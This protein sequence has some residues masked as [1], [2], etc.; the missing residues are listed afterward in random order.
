MNEIEVVNLAQLMERTSGDSG[1][2]IGLIDGPVAIAHPALRGSNIRETDSFK[3]KSNPN[4]PAC[5]HGTFVAGILSA[6][7][8]SGAPAIC[9]GCT[10]L[11][12]PILQDPAPGD[13]QIPGASAA[14]LAAAIVD[15]VNAG[16]RVLN[17]S[18]EVAQESADGRS[19]L[20]D[21]L[22]YAA[23]AGVIVAAAAG[24]QSTLAGSI[25]T[26]H[27]CVIPVAACDMNGMPTGES[28]L[29][30]TIGRRGLR[31]PGNGITSIGNG[32]RPLARGGTSVATPF[33][34]GTVALL[35][36]LFPTAPADRIRQAVT[37]GAKPR[38]AAVT[39][40]LLNAQAAYQV[41][42]T[43]YSMR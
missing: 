31:A 32:G 9:P 5:Q 21:A 4:S 25:I 24:N 28:N 33:V 15:C 34:T 17:L 39:P 18:L 19:A 8:G 23:Q 7:R 41:L 11:V 40:P 2:A 43:A 16:A 6:R 36:S 37:Y 1:V 26:R 10:L 22:N 13:V 30:A 12:R 42:S 35:L 27:P 38:R 3:N 14:D 20:E 29:G